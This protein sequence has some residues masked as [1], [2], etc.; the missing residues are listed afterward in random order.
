MKPEKDNQNNLP[1]QD[2]SDSSD[3]D[4]AFVE[5]RLELLGQPEPIDP[6]FVESLSTRLDAEFT[7]AITKVDAETGTIAE[8]NVDHNEFSTQQ[9]STEP[10]QRATPSVSRKRIW[11]RV[12]GGLVAATV[13]AVLFSFWVGQPL[14]TWAEMIEALKAAPWVQTD[15]G[16]TSSWFSASSQIVAMR[17]AGQSVFVSEKSGTHFNY[18]QADGQIYQSD[19][20]EPQLP[21]DRDLIAW[22]AG[23][24]QGTIR[25][26]GKRDANWKMVSE[27]AQHVD[28]ATGVWLKLTVVF[29]VHAA[30]SANV[31]R[32]LYT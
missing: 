1:K 29:E 22:L 27:T 8:T 9:S 17:D 4:E 14:T 11:Q 15:S 12:S 30:N 24:S 13:L 20:K 31:H 23:G 2:A 7:S 5:Q 26:T 3:R 32:R 19:T 28:D 16:R 25:G 21:L 10:V 6:Q 18:V